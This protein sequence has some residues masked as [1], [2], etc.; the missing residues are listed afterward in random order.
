MG[1]DEYLGLKQLWPEP[2]APNQT[3]LEYG[4]V[5]QADSVTGS[6]TTKVA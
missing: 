1:T 4:P 2:G 3:S 5:P 6:L